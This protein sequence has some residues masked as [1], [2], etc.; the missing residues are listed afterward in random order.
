[1][2]V[3]ENDALRDIGKSAVLPFDVSPIQL[4]TRGKCDGVNFEVIGRVRWG[5]TDGSWNEWYLQCSDGR[6]R[7]LGEA[8]G[9][10]LFLTENDKLS[11]DPV[12]QA[13]AA[14]DPIEVGYSIASFVATDV[15]EA[16]CLGGEGDLP[17]PTPTDWTMTSVDF[18]DAG[19][20]SL[21]VQRDRQG[22]SAYQG[23]YVSLIDL[24]PKGLRK[25]DGWT[26]PLGLQ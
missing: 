12:I 14:G 15:K 19:G 3:R 17:F 26:I 2:L 24:E 20:G 18:R 25:I 9:Q 10:Y 1:M 23:R 21:S 8:M 13:F 6:Q 22:V 5:W 4:G 11:S 7:W 16:T